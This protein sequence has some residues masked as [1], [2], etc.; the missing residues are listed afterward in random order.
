MTGLASELLNVYGKHM[1]YF[2]P[3]KALLNANDGHLR[4]IVTLIFLVFGTI[5]CTDTRQN[6]PQVGDKFPL[7]QLNQNNSLQQLPINFKDKFLL[8]NFWATW[9]APCRKEMPDLQ[10][11]STELDNTRYAVVGISVD[12]D[13]NLVKEFLLENDIQYPNFQD[14]SQYIASTLL[15]IKAFPE[16]IIVSPEGIILKKISGLITPDDL[17][18]EKLFSQTDITTTSQLESKRSGIPL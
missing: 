18:L 15:G 16:T 11:L 5:A 17:S 1:S 9:C 14:K 4:L 7:A 12:S 2:Y 13:T 8:I 10:K 6:L 3:H